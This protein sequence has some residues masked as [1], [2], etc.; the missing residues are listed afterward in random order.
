MMK[1]IIALVALLVKFP[2][3]TVI[4]LSMTLLGLVVVAIALPFSY[5]VE[6]A[7][8]WDKPDKRSVYDGW[9]FVSL[10]RWAQWCWGSDKYGARGNWFWPEHYSDTRSFKAMYVWLAIRNAC[11]NLNNNFGFS[12]EYKGEYIDY[13]GAKEI[14][15]NVGKTGVRLAW[16]RY[17]PTM[18]SLTI[19]L[20][21]GSSNKYFWWRLGY[22]HQP[23]SESGNAVFATMLLPNPL[24]RI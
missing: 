7:P 6:P 19:L 10:P 22:K 11:S 4:K 18:S 2:F 9:T 15:D 1:P 17:R 13:I 3:Y 14:D 24:K 20:R 12:Y 21:Y 23:H 5:D 16:H 8:E